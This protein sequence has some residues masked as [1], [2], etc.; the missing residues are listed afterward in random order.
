MQNTS[1]LSCYC[2]RTFITPFIPPSDS[3]TK[4]ITILAPGFCPSRNV[5][6]SR[7]C[8]KTS[9]HVLFTLALSFLLQTTAFK[10]CCIILTRLTKTFPNLA[11]QAAILTENSSEILEDYHSTHQPFTTRQ[12]YFAVL[13]EVPLTHHDLTLLFIRCQ[14][15]SPDI[16]FTSYNTSLFYTHI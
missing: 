2:R 4:I 10:V 13:T 7:P 16:S 11:L 15:P 8:T 14:I 9:I 3:T 1:D 12:T 6:V 5:Q